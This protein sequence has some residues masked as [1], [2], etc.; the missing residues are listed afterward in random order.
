LL[1]LPLRYNFNNFAFWDY[2]G[3]LLAHYLLR[4]GHQPLLGFGWQY[5]LL[6]LLIQELSFRLLGASPA[7]FLCLSVPCAVTVAVVMGKL[8]ILQGKASGRILVLLSLPLI[9]AFEP[10]LPHSLEPA[11]LSI[12][13]LSQAQGRRGLALASAVAACFTKPSMGYLYCL[14]L[15]IWIF[16]DSWRGLDSTDPVRGQSHPSSGSQPSVSA[17]WT[18]NRELRTLIP[19]ACTGIGLTLL[20]SMTFGWTILA[21]SL[22]PLSGARAYRALHFGWGGIARGLLYFPGVKPAY[23]V[24]TPVTFWFLGTLY[25]LIAGF[26]AASAIVRKK[27]HPPSDYELLCTCAILQIGFVALFYGSPASWTYYAYIVAAGI[28]ATEALGRLS[29]PA[30]AALCVLAALANYDGIRSAVSAWKTMKP[31]AATAGLYAAS[32]E[33]AEWDRVSSLARQN[34][35]ALFTQYGA[36]EILFPWLRTPT[37]AFIVPGVVSKTSIRREIQQF[38]SADLIIIP[39]IPEFGNPL[40]NGLGSDLNQAL[41]GTVLV[42]KGTYFQVYRRLATEHRS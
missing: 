20:L 26:V 10:D 25:L 4:Q 17:R 8:A 24:G 36:A 30:I 12:G 6:P 27:Q 28:M 37:G 23:Y 21:C 32:G 38:R 40:L 41:C 7:S 19:A 34:D 39:T 31:S 33:R 14:V 18:G 22:L 2:G 5:G 16:L 15:L 13:L 35:S 3:F 42:F 11:L 9:T 29:V 1:R